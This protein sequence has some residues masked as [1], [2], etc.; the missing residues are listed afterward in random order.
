MVVDG[1]TMMSPRDAAMMSRRE[2]Q[3]ARERGVALTKESKVAVW[4][5]DHAQGVT[6]CGAHLDEDEDQSQDQHGVMD[7]PG[8]DAFAWIPANETHER[9][10]SV[11]SVP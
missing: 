1:D 9:S 6:T 4:G 11:S 3:K 8:C 5:Q 7:E 10:H 2:Q